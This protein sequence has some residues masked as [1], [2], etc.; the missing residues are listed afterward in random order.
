MSTLPDR[1]WP[2]KYNREVLSKSMRNFSSFLGILQSSHV[3]H[4]R[5]TRNWSQAVTQVCCYLIQRRATFPLADRCG[6]T[7]SPL[8]PSACNVKDASLFYGMYVFRK[9][10]TSAEINI[11]S[12][13][14]IYSCLKVKSIFLVV[15]ESYSSPS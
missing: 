2:G 5:G 13:L 9:R 7:V 14:L 1:N 8:S 12:H 10:N 6:G 11:T 3:V 15:F 4:N